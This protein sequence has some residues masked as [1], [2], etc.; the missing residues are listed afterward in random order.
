M[1]D[2]PKDLDVNKETPMCSCNKPCILW[3]SKT[4]K[5]PDRF[6]GGAASHEPNNVHS[7]DG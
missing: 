3:V 6:S 4:E 7:F 2:I 5:N 1:W